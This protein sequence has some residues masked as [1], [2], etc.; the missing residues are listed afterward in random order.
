MN[1]L[2]DMESYWGKVIYSVCRGN[3]ADMRALRTFDIIDFFS[4]L[5]EV[6]QRKK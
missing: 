2:R 5:E 1:E 4:Y 3:P 6:I